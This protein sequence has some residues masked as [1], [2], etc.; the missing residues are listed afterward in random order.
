MIIGIGTCTTIIGDTSANVLTTTNTTEQIVQQVCVAVIC[1]F[2]M[3]DDVVLY[4]S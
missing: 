1:S 4:K 2:R 3:R